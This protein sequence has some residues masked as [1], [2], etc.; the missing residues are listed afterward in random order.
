MRKYT[1]CNQA[2]KAIFDKQLKALQS[3]IPDIEK[4]EILMDVDSSETAILHLNNKQRIVLHNSYYIDAV[5]IESDVD[6][7]KYFD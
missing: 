6:L 5:Y 2:D 4:T 7:E 1:I 3:H